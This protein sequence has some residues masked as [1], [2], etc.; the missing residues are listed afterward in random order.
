MKNKGQISIHFHR[1]TRRVKMKIFSRLQKLFLV[2]I[3]KD[4]DYY[5]N[6]GT[7]MPPENV[8][9]LL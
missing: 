8:C 5:I 4:N 1:F 9:K 3:T 6:G 2:I 7:E